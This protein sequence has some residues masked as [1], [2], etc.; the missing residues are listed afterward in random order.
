MLKVAVFGSKG[1]MGAE[2]C[3]A[4]DAVPDMQLVA[5][6]DQGDSREQALAADV[7]VDFTHPNVVMEN[8]EWC[9]KNGINV[10]VGTT[11]FND[12]RLAKVEQL[13]SENP[14]VGVVIAAN[15]SIGA[16]VMMHAAALAA[17]Y[18]ESVEIIELHHNRK[19]DAPSGTSATTAKMIAKSR[20]SA[21]LGEIQ[22]ATVSELDGARGCEVDQIRV[23][24][25]RLAGLVAH[26]EVMFGNQGETLTIRHDS[27]DRASFMPGVLSGVRAVVERSGLTL[28]IDE[29]LG[30][31]AN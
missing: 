10:V 5:G 15:F 2:V 16:I 21:G 26:Q 17:K 11:G 12:E 31:G 27:L 7:V 8:I 18:F 9:V 1:R 3:K 19:A 4:V 30:L 20:Q 24:S 22:D 28:G 25:V 14:K 29:L 6:I 13:L 23:H